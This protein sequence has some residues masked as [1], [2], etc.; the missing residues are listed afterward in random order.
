MTSREEHIAQ[1]NQNVEKDQSCV[2]RIMGKLTDLDELLSQTKDDLASIQ[3]GTDI[4]LSSLW[5]QLDNVYS[6]LRRIEAGLNSPEQ[7]MQGVRRF[8]ENISRGT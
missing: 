6:G 1:A 2:H 4:Q 5:M 7:A 8:L 3:G